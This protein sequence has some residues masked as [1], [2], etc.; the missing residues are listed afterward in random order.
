MLSSSDSEIGTRPSYSSPLKRALQVLRPHGM[1]IPYS[2]K[3]YYCFKYA[4]LGEHSLRLPNAAPSHRGADYL[5][6]YIT[7]YHWLKYNWL[8]TNVTPGRS[9]L[10]TDVKIRTRKCI[11]LEHRTHSIIP[12]NIASRESHAIEK[13]SYIGVV[14]WVGVFPGCFPSRREQYSVFTSSISPRK[15]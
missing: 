11:S 12:V 4:R 14:E 13:A 10:Q 2:T 5:V 15:Y 1:L 8:S 7:I 9:P 6:G 3:K